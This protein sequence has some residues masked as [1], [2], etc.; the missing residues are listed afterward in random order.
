MKSNES[1]ES[2]S[3]YE[4]AHKMYLKNLEMVKGEINPV[5]YEILKDC[6]REE[7]MEIIAAAG[8]GSDVYVK[9][10]DWLYSTLN[11]TEQVFILGDEPINYSF[12]DPGL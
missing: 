7:A 9:E 12:E 2:L 8:K 10:L 3:S 11:E 6:Q 5:L 4:L 1:N